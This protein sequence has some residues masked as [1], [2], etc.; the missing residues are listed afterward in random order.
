M[1]VCSESF[2]RDAHLARSAFTYVLHC[3][4][5]CVVLNMSGRRYMLVTD[6]GWNVEHVLS[7]TAARLSGHLV[8]ICLHGKL[9]TSWAVSAYVCKVY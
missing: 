8:T 7:I 5:V 1:L 9:V 4:K 2:W 3:V 6:F